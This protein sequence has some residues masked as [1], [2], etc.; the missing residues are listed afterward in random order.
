MVFNSSDLLITLEAYVSSHIKFVEE[1]KELAE[2]D[3][4]RKQDKESWSVLECIEHLNLYA[5]FY[6]KE[7]KARM[8]ASKHSNTDTFKSGFLGN[9]IASDLLP[10]EG[11]KTMKT[12]KS[13]NPIY[14]KLKKEEVL[15]N[16]IENQT[17]LLLLLNTAKE[18]NLTKIKTS[19]TIPL[20]KFRLGDTFRFVI[21]HNERHMVQAKKIL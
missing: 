7:I 18:K 5:V 6:N 3:L 21:Y 11:M 15:E 1:L 16:F 14:T 10:K 2:S 8:K 17:E 13:K 20:L 19:L 12:F 9:K 4:Q